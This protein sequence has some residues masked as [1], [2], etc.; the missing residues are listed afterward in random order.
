MRDEQTYIKLYRKIK[1]NELLKK[2]NDAFVM[3]INLLLECDRK[4][5]EYSTGRI[6]LGKMCNLTPRRAYSKM[7]LLEKYGFITVKST[8]HYTKIYILNWKKYQEKSGQPSDNQVTTEV[9]PVDN[10]L[11]PVGISPVGNQEVENGQPSDNQVTL[12]NNK[13]LINNNISEVEKKNKKKKDNRDVLGILNR[14]AK[15][16]FRIEPKSFE[17]TKKQ[18]TDEEIT[19]ALINMSHDSWHKE[20]MKELSA[21]YM[22]R[23][24]IIDKFLNVK[25]SSTFIRG[26]TQKTDVKKLPVQEKELTPEQKERGTVIRQLLDKGQK[27][28]GIG[29]KTTAELKEILAN[30]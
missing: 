11:Y 30:L 5:G 25:E 24:S 13:E 2:D 17:K 1:T 29:S 18:F 26:S 3:F 27:L 20:K 22:L 4:T 10:Q 9:S 23:P 28:S 6:Q 7:K 15:R 12:N 19:K 21:D 14:I 8:T 16:N